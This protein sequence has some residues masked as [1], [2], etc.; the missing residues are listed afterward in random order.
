MPPVA[1]KGYTLVFP[2]PFSDIPG[3][4]F[5][6]DPYPER[7]N[8]D[9]RALTTLVELPQAIYRE[10][11][12]EGIQTVTLEG[13]F[14]VKSRLADGVERT[15]AQMFDLLEKWVGDYWER[16]GKDSKLQVEFHD[17]EKNRHHYAEIMT[18]AAPKGSENRM[19]DRYSMELRLYTTIKQ[20]LAV[21]TVDKLLLARS[22]LS[23]FQRALAA[24]GAAGK[25]LS[26]LVRSATEIINRYIVQPLT[27]LA[28]ALSDL[29]SG[30]TEFVAFPLRTLNRIANA[31]TDFFL[32]VGEIVGTAL[33]TMA[34]VL[35]QTKRALHRLT[36]WPSLFK[37]TV[38]NAAYDL[39]NAYLD[40]NN[41]INPGS[42]Q[43]A[44]RRTS[45]AYTGV[46]QA[47]VRAGD[48]LQRIALRELGD[49]SRWHD[50]ALVNG[51]AS[52]ADLIANATILIPTTSTTPNSAVSGDVSDTQYSTAERLYGRDFRVIQTAR[53]KLSM[54][55]EAN[56]DLATVGGEANLMQAVMLKTRIA[57]GTL[58]ENPDYGLRPLV[59]KRQAPE[60]A[61][62]L[63]FGLRVAAES[64]PR[65][66]EANVEVV[67]AG[68]V[69]T[70]D[71]KL[72]PVGASG[73]HPL[74][75][76]VGGI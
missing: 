25:T 43:Q 57:Q 70:Y 66:E 74:N 24:I 35:R 42:I 22:S 18:F 8:R 68:N 12:G 60:N 76:V 62:L 21:P 3:T 26:G 46:R 7:I 38:V 37:S 65:I 27:Q 6:L 28:S 51:F 30:V 15:G 5:R 44:L 47:K 59:G 75:T 31:V 9:R 50:I 48:T 10:S 72:T 63:A 11:H 1:S 2:S 71:Y 61:D 41:E 14:G 54:V 20:K 19:H 36:T 33:T 39:A 49:A 34:N 40:L 64:D 4:V 56:N 32:A 23:W 13:T 52:N 29:V 73:A 58:L 17:W 69:T 55:I 16:L 45:Q 67:T 53:G